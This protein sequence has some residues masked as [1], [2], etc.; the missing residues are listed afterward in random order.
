MNADGLFVY[1]SLRSGGRD[2]GW[3]RRT[4]PEGITPA[5][6]AGRLFHL[7][8]TSAA[9]MVPRPEPATLPPGPG[10]VAGEFVGYADEQ[11]LDSAIADLDA[12]EDVAGGLYERRLLPVILTS[13]HRYHAWV[14][15]F[16]EDR[17]H[18]LER[19][20]TELTGGDFREY[21]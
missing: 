6:T 9:A 7:P 19:E 15:L 20:S 2:H 13:G 16:P 17:L 8:D 4:D 18:R 3:L 21:L 12:L 14:Y 10:W 1:G 11:E 5:H